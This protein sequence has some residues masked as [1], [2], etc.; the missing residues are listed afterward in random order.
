MPR[1][2]SSIDKIRAE[3][4]WVTETPDPNKCG[5]ATSDAAKRLDTS[6]E[7]VLALSQQ[8]SG[9][10]GGSTTVHHAVNMNGAE[11]RLAATWSLDERGMSG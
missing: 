2:Y 5:S 6:P 11:V 3:L 9:R 1:T 8:S 10:F 7:G 4:A